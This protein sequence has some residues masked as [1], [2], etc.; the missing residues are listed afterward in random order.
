MGGAGEKVGIFP[1]KQT[2]GRR[3]QTAELRGQRTDDRWAG[4]V[5]GQGNRGKT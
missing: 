1:G 3:G 4:P 5:S 2:E